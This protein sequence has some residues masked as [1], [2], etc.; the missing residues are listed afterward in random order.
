MTTLENLGYGD[1]PVEADAEL[2]DTVLACDK[3]RLIRILA[4]YL[5]NAQKYADGPTGVFVERHDPDP[6]DPFDETTVR[7][8]VEDAGPGVPEEERG[9]IFDRFNRGDQGGSRGADIG[10][11]LGLALAAEHARLQ[12]GRVWV[13]D[14]H[15]GGQGSRFVVELPLLEPYDEELEEDDLSAATP[16]AASALTLT[17]EH[18]AITLDDTLDEPAPGRSAR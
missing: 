14:R 13:E 4:N 7:V 1:V 8:G 9:R 10:V 5:N 17:G 3:R 11:G 15:D 18:S 2:E 6:D 16:E 12:G